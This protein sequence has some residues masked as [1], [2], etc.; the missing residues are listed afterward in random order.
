MARRDRDRGRTAKPMAAPTIRE[1]ADVRGSGRMRSVKVRE[2]ESPTPMM[3]PTLRTSF[4]SK[5]RR[6]R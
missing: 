3:C 4:G 6:G 1:T 2:L 5:R